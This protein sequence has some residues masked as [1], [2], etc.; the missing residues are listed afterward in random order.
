[1]KAKQKV[2]RQ[3]SA[4]ILAVFSLVLLGLSFWGLSLPQTADLGG[5]IVLNV[6][7]I[8][9]ATVPGQDTALIAEFCLLIVLAVVFLLAFVLP[10]LF[11][12]R[13]K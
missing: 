13:K 2:A 9:L 7:A 4:P 6:R 1:M 5:D 10:A 3:I 12:G 11:N 8:P